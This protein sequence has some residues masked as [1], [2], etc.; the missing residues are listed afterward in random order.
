[1]EYVGKALRHELIERALGVDCWV[2]GGKVQGLESGEERA[3]KQRVLRTFVA[4][5]KGVGQSLVSV[6]IVVRRRKLMLQP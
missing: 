6:P 2:S 3:E 5:A 1:M 4:R